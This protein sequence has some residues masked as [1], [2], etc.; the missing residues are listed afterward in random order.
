MNGEVSQRRR[1]LRA[2][3]EQDTAFR[4]EWKK[5]KEVLG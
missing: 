1:V 3:K 5:V 4:K 2:V